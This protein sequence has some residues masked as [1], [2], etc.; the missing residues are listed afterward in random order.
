[1]NH[2]TIY[3]TDTCHWCHMAKE[4]FKQKGIQYDEI[5]VTGNVEKQKELIQ[6]S[7]Q[8]GVPVIFVGDKMVLG[9]DR[10][11]INQYLNISN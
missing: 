4:Y 1:M 10:E 7:G 3:T 9:F 11:K 8:F 6:K 5:N 2:V